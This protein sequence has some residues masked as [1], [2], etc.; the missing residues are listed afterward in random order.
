MSLLTDLTQIFSIT[1]LI[2]FLAGAGLMGVGA[3][4]AYASSCENRRSS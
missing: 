4:I 2:I 1:D 3:L